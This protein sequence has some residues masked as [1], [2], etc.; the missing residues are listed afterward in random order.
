MSLFWRLILASV[1]IYALSDPLAAAL[2]PGQLQGDMKPIELL[3]LLV[4]M[5]LVLI[6][7][8]FLLGRWLRPLE[9]LADRM[10][11]A[12]LL[13]G[14]QRLPITGVGEIAT[15]ER[16]FNEMIERLERERRDA[17][18]YALAAQEAE[19]KRLARGLHDE[20]SQSMTAVLLQLKEVARDAS[21]EQ[22]A[23]LAAA[24]EVVKRSLNDAH[25][26][27]QELRPELLDSLG[28]ASAL[29]HLA[30][31]VEDN[32]HIRVHRKIE[33]DLPRL[34][35]YVELVVYR[36]AQESLT[37]VARH[38]QASEATLSVVR[39]DGSVVLQVIDD[40]CGLDPTKPEGGG[41]RGI[42]ERA[43]IVG[44]AAA[45]K[46]GHDDGGVEVRLEIPITTDANDRL[47]APV[48]SRARA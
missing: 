23:R 26:L 20:V 1:L 11:T 10:K 29:T 21:P 7:Y 40:G 30:K 27:A 14:G 8:G 17:G 18:A 3:E 22:R 24:Q 39:D 42:R 31:T 46:A 45:I 13:R 2:V 35:P 5:L 16:A 6:V 47:H 28:L 48:G 37:N 12:D 34:D 36:V 9:R 15:L 4:S 38:S 33:R 41:L 44:G 19:R 25:R 43:L 32:A